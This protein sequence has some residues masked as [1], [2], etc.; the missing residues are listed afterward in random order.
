[1][2]ITDKKEL[3]KYTTEHRI[4]Q[5]I[6]GIEVTKNGRIFACF[7]SGGIK[8]TF[9]NFV[10]LVKSDDGVNF[11]EPIAIAKAQ[12]ARCYDPCIWI[13]PL[14]RLWLIWSVM[15]GHGVYATICTDPDAEEL[16]WGEEFRIGSDV[17]MNKPTVLSS[18]EWLFPLAVWDNG[19][20][21]LAEEFDTKQERGS[22]VYQSTDNGETF[23]KLG[24]ADVPERDFDEHMLLE[25]QDCRLAMYVR[26]KYGIGMSYSTDKGHTWSAGT[27]SGLGG[28]N[29]RFHIRRLRSGRVLQV[30]HVDFTKRN[31]L[32]ALLSEDDGKTWPYRLLLDG[33]DMVSYPDMAE[34]EDGYL[35]IIYDRE[36]GDKKDSLKAAYACA[37]EILYAKI[38][39]EDIVAGKL[40]SEHSKLHCIVS[41]LGKYA[42]EHEDPYGELTASE[43]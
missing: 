18:G 3:K 2:L 37:R 20:R 26:T 10:I 1:M 32:M 5:G 22:F 43:G 41:K 12:N 27:D 8:E 14:G 25:L 31:N 6:P 19:I 13:D 39:E 35:Y 38:T 11:S 28:P 7:Y 15:P 40:V 34:G 42:E 16:R 36:R 23:Q 30:N 9:G 17:M 29:S 4:W 33:R 24:A 21:V